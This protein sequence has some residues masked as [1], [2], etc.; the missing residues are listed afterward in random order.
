MDRKKYERKSVIECESN[1]EREIQSESK[2][3]RS[4]QRMIM[5]IMYTKPKSD[6][7]AMKWLFKKNSL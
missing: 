5:K 7:N 1:N 2:R 6:L 4:K 3:E